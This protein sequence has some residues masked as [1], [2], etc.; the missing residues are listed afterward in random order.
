MSTGCHAFITVQYRYCTSK[1]PSIMNNH[2]LI[3][4]ST[5]IQTTI[6]YLLT[7]WTQQKHAIFL[8]TSWRL[9]RYCCKWCI[10]DRICI[11]AMTVLHLYCCSNRIASVLPQ[12]LY[13]ICVAACSCTTSLEWY[14]KL[15]ST[16]VVL[17]I[18][19]NS[20]LT[21]CL[22]SLQFFFFFKKM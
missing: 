18:R 11:A 6:I 12:W 5:G 9:H 21:S 17:P 2:G 8:R 7:Q 22:L 14:H 16:K 4:F 13:S 3:R 19:N 20:S 15:P 10:R 1:R